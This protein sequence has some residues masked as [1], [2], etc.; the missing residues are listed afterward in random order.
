MINTLVFDLGG[1]VMNHNIPATI[2]RFTELMGDNIAFLGLQSNGE[3]EGIDEETKRLSA[4]V[5]NAADTSSLMRDFELGY[6]ST[7]DFVSAILPLCKEGTTR[8]EILEAWDLMHAGI[9]TWRFEKLREWHAQFATYA[10]SNNNEE[11]WRHIHATY[12][13]F[14]SYFDACF[15]S[16]LLHIG[17]P[18]TR[19][20]AIA[21]KT[22]MQDYE[23]RHIPY[24]REE[25]IFVDDLAANREAARSYGW[26]ACASFE[27]LEDLLGKL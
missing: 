27:E 4:A 25:T 26:Q 15:A 10:L 6:A 11:H 8:D 12:P 3:A 9:P 17:K 20:F 5:S 21:E 22:I 2:A 18:D 23:K 19:I 13:D 1:V 24:N 14:E 7:N 16:H